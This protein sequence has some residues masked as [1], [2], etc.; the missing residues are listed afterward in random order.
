MSSIQSRSRRPSA[1][2]LVSF[3]GA[4]FLAISVGPLFFLLN[5]GYSIV[6]MAW[7]A[8]RSGEYGRLFWS[9]ATYATIDVP[10]AARAGLPLRQPILPWLMVVGISA[11]QIGM[12]VRKLRGDRSEPWYDLAGVG[13]SAFDYATTGAGLAFAPFVAATS[14]LVHGLWAIIALLLAVPL[15]FTFEALLARVLKGKAHVRQRDPDRDRDLPRSR[16]DADNDRLRDL[17]LDDRTP[18]R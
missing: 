1:G 9:A 5:G 4:I 7:L 8:D 16:A 15:T 11:L 18:R 2:G 13:V 12:L 17:L 10:I 6:G 14:P 3:I